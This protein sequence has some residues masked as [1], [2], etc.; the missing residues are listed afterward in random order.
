MRGLFLLAW[1]SQSLRYLFIGG[2]SYIVELSVLLFL[3]KALLLVPEFAVACS[4]LIGL[5]VS[6]VLQKY[7]AFRSK[8]SDKKT[9]G[10]QAFLYG[11][12]VLFNLTFT[13]LFVRFFDDLLG[14]IIA[15]TVAL[16][17]TVSWNYVVYKE[18]FKQSQSTEKAIE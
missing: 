15:R 16:L 9:I 13:V 1:E 6:F 10:K 4:F 18:I 14:L 5:L 7:T 11:A 8:A 12:L 3:A 17:L 2:V